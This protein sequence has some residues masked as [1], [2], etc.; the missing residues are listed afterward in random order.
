MRL[1]GLPAVA[2]EPERVCVLCSPCQH[3]NGYPSA[4][5]HEPR[6]VPAQ[7]QDTKSGG[8]SCTSSSFMVRLEY[9]HAAAHHAVHKYK[10]S[11]PNLPKL[12]TEDPPQGKTARSKLSQNFSDVLQGTS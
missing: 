12:R 1:F 7:Y 8:C 6:H 10:R 3:G 11:R 2:Q 4:L 5:L 9:L